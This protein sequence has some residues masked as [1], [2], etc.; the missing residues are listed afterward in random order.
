MRCP[1]APRY[2]CCATCPGC[3]R[4]G[5]ARRRRRLCVRCGGRSEEQKLC[6]GGRCWRGRAGQCHTPGVRRRRDSQSSAGP[7]QEGWGW[8]RAE[9]DPAAAGVFPS[10]SPHA[11][12][13]GVPCVLRTP[14]VFSWC[15]GQPL[16][17]G[18]GTGHPP[19]RWVP[20]GNFGEPQ[21]P[22]VPIVKQA[23]GMGWGSA[24]ASSSLCP[25]V[26]GSSLWHLMGWGGGGWEKRGV[27]GRTHR[28]GKQPNWRGI[29]TKCR[30]QER[31]GARDHAEC[32]PRRRSRAKDAGRTAAGEGGWKGFGGLWLLET[33]SFFQGTNYIFYSFS[34]KKGT[35]LEL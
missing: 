17:H 20:A 24:A 26:Q 32:S 33:A 5:S 29:C 9:G 30:G 22:L 16:P 6:R 35:V 14:G 27:L 19:R 31:S 13:H 1:G 2:F 25:G 7:Q 23:P 8:W 10:L 3:P 28:H 15:E 34:V 11:G 12:L 21:L 4:F 18:A